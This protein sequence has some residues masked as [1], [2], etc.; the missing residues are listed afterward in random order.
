MTDNNPLH[1]PYYADQAVQETVE[2]VEN[3]EMARDTYRIRFR[4]PELAARITPGQ[5][6]MVKLALSVHH[7]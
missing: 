6:L 7:L 5:F 4:F 2:V 1:A 3:V